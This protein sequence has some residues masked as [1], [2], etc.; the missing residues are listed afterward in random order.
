MMV[1]YVHE[2]IS[3]RNLQLQLGIRQRPCVNFHYIKKMDISFLQMYGTTTF[4]GSF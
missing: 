1:K 4:S 3:P 2:V